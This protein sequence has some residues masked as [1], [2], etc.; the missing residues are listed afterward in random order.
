MSV[1]PADTEPGRAY[2]ECLNCRR[3]IQ[4]CH[5]ECSWR[6]QEDGYFRVNCFLLKEA[7]PDLTTIVA[8]PRRR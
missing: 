1:Q 8:R 3:R 5:L 7:E 2:A 6:H 4:R